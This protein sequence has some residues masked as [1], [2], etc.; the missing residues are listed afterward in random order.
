MKFEPGFLKQR[1]ANVVIVL[2]HDEL[3]MTKIVPLWEWH[4]PVGSREFY[5][6]TTQMGLDF[7]EA[8]GAGTVLVTVKDFRTTEDH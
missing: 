4:V 3:N 2:H 6:M 8:C 1:E 5:K 7:A